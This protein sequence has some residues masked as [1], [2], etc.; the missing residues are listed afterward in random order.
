MCVHIYTCVHTRVHACVWRG[1]GGV[2]SKVEKH[3][4][5]RV[6]SASLLHLLAASLIPV[7][8]HSDR[9]GTN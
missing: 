9:S 1:G 4:F 2:R 7:F 3:S 6:P 5:E 8:I